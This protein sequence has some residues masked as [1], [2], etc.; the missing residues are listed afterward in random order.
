MAN[1]KSPTKRV[2]V[3]VDGSA[4]ALRALKFAAQRSENSKLI[5][6]LVQDTVPKFTRVPRSLVAEHR[7]R[8]AEEALGPARAIV[9]K[10]GVDA[11]FHDRAGEPAETIVR[12]A[13]AMRCAEIVM[14]KRGL[15]RVTGLLLGSVS[16]QVAHLSDL[17]VTLVK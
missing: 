15:G 16:R 1:T 2:L 5:V 17:P 12:F 3:A 4:S 13:R 11:D 7:A 9:A 10:L 6:L 14:G 8:V